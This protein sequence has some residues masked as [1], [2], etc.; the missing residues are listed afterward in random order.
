[1]RDVGLNKSLDDDGVFVVDGDNEA[2]VF[3]SDGDDLA[4]VL[5]ADLEFL[6]GDVD[7][8]VAADSAKYFLELRNL[9][10]FG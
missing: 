2:V 1:M 9:D 7:G 6:L 3:D 4:F 5:P 8:A 10:G